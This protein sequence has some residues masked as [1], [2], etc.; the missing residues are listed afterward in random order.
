MNSPDLNI[1]DANTAIAKLNAMREKGLD[2]RDPVRFHFMQALSAKSA[3]HQGAARA[4]LDQRLRTLI[5]S[6][7]QYTL[8]AAPET[9]GPQG[10]NH[11]APA[12]AP[13]AALNAYIAEQA[14]SASTSPVRDAYPE[15]PA[16]DE[17]RKVWAGLRTRQQLRQSQAQVHDNAGPL[18]SDHLVHQALLLMRDTSPGYLHHFLAHVDA[19]SWMEQLHRGPTNKET[20]RSGNAKKTTRNPTAKDAATR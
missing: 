20:P 11:S 13:L 2:L 9:Q 8:T 18:N 14:M 1:T 15:L 3:A 19:L 4:V 16:I 5:E 7:E 12:Q 10:K 17:F 6:Y